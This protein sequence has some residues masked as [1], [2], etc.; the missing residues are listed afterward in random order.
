MSTGAWLFCGIVAAALIAPAGV[1]AAVNSHVAI[2]NVGNATTATVDAEHQLLTAVVAPSDIVRISGAA[3]VASNG[4]SVIYTP[5]TG[6]ALVLVNVTVELE[7][8]PGG[9]FVA[10]VI[11]SRKDCGAPVD[12][13]ET[14]VDRHEE[15]HTYPAG[16]PLARLSLGTGYA[17]GIWAT[18]YL[19]PAS[20]LPATIAPSG[21]LPPFHR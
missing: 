21:K 20:Q 5:P 16:L 15:Q 12:W 3:N 7:I 17:S 6:K 4:C 14:T 11:S 10:D 8:Q 19:I 1:Y 13:F 18:G 2:G 9:T